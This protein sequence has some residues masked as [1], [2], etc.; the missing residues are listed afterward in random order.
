MEHTLNHLSM[1]T[2]LQNSV[3][4]HTT[5]QG[6]FQ[7][8]LT[9]N[10]FIFVTI[11]GTVYSWEPVLL[12]ISC[13]NSAVALTFPR[14][15][16]ID[17]LSPFLLFSPT[18]FFCDTQQKKR[19][20]WPRV[21]F[22]TADRHEYFP[23]QGIQQERRDRRVTR[24]DSQG[25]SKHLKFPDLTLL[26]KETGSVFLYINIS[27]MVCV[28][29]FILSLAGRLLSLRHDKTTKRFFCQLCSIFV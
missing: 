18:S 22:T 16:G 2:K 14:N 1:M 7:P 12:P 23:L 24:R 25:T 21:Q 4:C 28:V 5:T 10:A 13:S 9:Q 15:S 20:T 27:L 26:G 29:F 8:E 6:L 19:S 17:C 3:S 11:Y